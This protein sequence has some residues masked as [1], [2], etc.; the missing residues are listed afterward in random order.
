[1]SG[2]RGGRRLGSTSAGIALLGLALGLGLAAE[3]SSR[4]G[5]IAQRVSP[6]WKGYRVVL[7]DSSVP[8]A[9]VLSRLRSAGL[10]KVLSESTEPVL[11]SDWSKL[12]VLPL[13]EVQ[14]LAETGDPRADPYVQR[15]GLWFKGRAGNEDCRIYYVDGF[16]SS[17]RIGEALAEYRGKVFLPDAASAVAGKTTAFLDFAIA[18][19]LVL[20]AAASSPLIGREE[21]GLREG[22]SRLRFGLRSDRLALRLA[23]AAPWIVLAAAGGDCAYIAC[24]GGI[25]VVELA[26]LLD[27][28]LDELK[29]SGLASALGSARRQGPPPFAIAVCA[30]TAAAFAPDSLLGMSLAAAGSCVA[31]AGYAFLAFGVS[32]PRRYVPLPIASPRRLRA[33]VPGKVRGVLAS[34]A[35]LAWG[36]EA[37]LAPAPVANSDKGMEYPRPAELKGSARPLPAEAKARAAAET[38]NVLPGLASYLEHVAVQEAIPYLRLGEARADPFSEVDLPLPG[39]EAKTLAFT[40]SWARGA[41][42]AMP[43]GGVEA[44]LLAQGGAVAGRYGGPEPGSPVGRRGRPL[45]PTRCL[46]YILL[47]IAPLARFSAGLPFARESS[48]GELRQEA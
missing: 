14:A 23:L 5:G 3:A 21:T 22:L 30:A 19:C 20:A 45:A 13:A 17:S 24:L 40:D 41:Y 16:A 36:L 31:L 38:G 46:L 28:P 48:S 8:E 33:A 35:V 44:M 42:A 18:L 1:M 34:A 25:A 10:D 15:L 32:A 11:V 39:G 6:A 26:D 29:S 12:R 4:G 2:K 9:E 27:I 7:V 47:L 43:P 37:V